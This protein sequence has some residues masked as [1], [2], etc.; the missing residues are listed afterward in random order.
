MAHSD[1][2]GVYIYAECPSPNGLP[3]IVFRYE[4]MRDRNIK[5]L[6]DTPFGPCMVD[7]E[8]IVAGLADADLVGPPPT[9]EIT[10]PL[11]R[12]LL[13]ATGAGQELGI[14]PGWLLARARENRVPHVRLG[15][16]V[17]FDPDEVC[18]FFHRSADRHAN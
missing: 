3:R 18:A 9:S 5:V 17:R 15:K 8:R 12:R 14:E 16:Y 2:F 6:L 1:M 10:R 13:D 11:Q 7:L 4:K